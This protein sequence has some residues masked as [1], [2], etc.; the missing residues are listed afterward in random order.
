MPQITISLAAKNPLSRLAATLLLW[1]MTCCLLPAA[2][3][4]A[5]AVATAS[6]GPVS[7]VEQLAPFTFG[8]E[9]NPWSPRRVTLAPAR[10]IWLP[11]ART[12][13]NTFVLFRKEL[14]LSEKP[15]RAVGWIAADSRYRLS[16]NGQRIQWGPAPCDPRQLDADPLDIS[17]A[18]RPGKNVIGVEVLYYGL[19]DGTWPAGKPGLLFNAVIEAAEARTQRVVSDESWQCMVDRAHPPGHAKR[20]FLRALQEEFDA[21]QHPQGWDSPDYQPDDH[22]TAAML[23]DCPADKPP[24]SGH[25]ASNDLVDYVAPAHSALRA[26]QIP[27]VKEVDVPVAHLADSGRVRW[28]RDPRD[29]FDFRMPGSFQIAREA[30]AEAIEPGAWRLPATP[31]GTGV[32]ATFEFREQ[33]VGF[34]HFEIDAP[35]GTTIELM[36]QEAHDPKATIWLDTQFYAWSRYVCREGV[37]RFEPFDYESLRWMQLHIRN[38]S[39]PV[40]LRKIGVRRRLFD[41]PHEPVVRTSEP[42]LQR[43]ID[44]SINTL[45]NSAIETIV[46]GMARERQQYSGD[47]GH[48]LIAIRT[49]FGEPRLSRRF[50]R[51]FSEGQAPEG[52]FLDS[53][54]AFD[55]LARVAQKQIDG[56][57]WG[58]LLDHGV[59]FNFDCWKHYLET[60]D[61]DALVEPYP[62]LARFADYLKTLRGKDGLLPVEGLGIPTVWI[63]HVAYHK[64]RDKQ[65][66]FNLYAAAMLR[67]ALAPMAELFDQR[68]RAGGFRKLGDELLDATR[69]RFWSGQEGLFVDNLPW[70]DEDREIHTSDRALANAILFDQ[71]PGGR[72]EASVREL[73]GCPKRMGFSYPCNACWRLWALAKVGRGD[74][75]V[76]DFRERW[77]TMRSVLENN[78]LQEDWQVRPDSGSQWSHCAVAPLFVLAQDIAGIR[79]ASPGYARCEIRPQL[80][81]LNDLELV[82]YTPRGPIH[83]AAVSTAQGHKLRLT[84]PERIEAELL[85]PPRSAQSV[86]LPAIAGDAPSGLKRFRLTAGQANELFVKRP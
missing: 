13:P 1:Q 17:S 16:V 29:W 55:R 30:I 46:D 69:R 45:R 27:L 34:P 23:L 19:G 47:G 39:R 8:K 85:L 38:A 81:D 9:V 79:P 53:W 42:A 25:Y 72:T 35:A 63:D 41:W 14:T 21:R 58:P 77:A 18:L 12:L 76:R 32:F 37:N 26:R 10:W 2:A 74:V 54:P 4:D 33:V 51:T 11:S 83:F 43:L 60:G 71:C 59:G 68:E 6:L 50:L 80:A 75:V 66:A 65:C 31:A 73:A 64:Q 82:V 40:I 70:L 28:N 7:S 3:D 62:R 56:A 22:W 48:Q 24:S 78:T 52:Y 49:V 44:A 15:T 57:Y 20:W 84:L 36:V 67:H 86:S 5:P 61:R